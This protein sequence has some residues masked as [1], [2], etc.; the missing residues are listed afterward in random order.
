MSTESTPSVDA[1]PPTTTA[2]ECAGWRE[3]AR[4][5]ALIREIAAEA[6][7]HRSTVCKHVGGREGCTHDTRDDHP[8]TVS[9]SDGGP[10]IHGRT[11]TESIGRV[12]DTLRE[13]LDDTLGDTIYFQAGALARD[14]GLGMGGQRVAAILA[15]LAD[16]DGELHVKR[17]N[18]G[19]N[20]ARWM[21][22]HAGSGS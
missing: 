4:D 1:L 3:R 10:G 9:G 22:T 18:P 6:R 2:A 16:G 5:G 14:Y 20:R 19:A 7:F 11:D 8:A 12:R 13:R 17:T 15:E 21:A